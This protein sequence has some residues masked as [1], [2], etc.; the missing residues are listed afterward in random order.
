M[1]NEPSDEKLEKRARNVLLYQISRSMKTKR[2]LAQI[3]VK[4]EIPDHVALPL[5]DRFE[6][7]EL[8][9]DAAFARAFVVSK[10]A[11]GGKSA[12]ALRRELKIKGV[13]DDL[14]AEALIEL[15]QEKEQLIANRLAIARYQRLMKLEPDVRQRRLFGF[16]QRRGFNSAIISRAIR[17]A[18]AAG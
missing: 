14:I 13:A 16:L 10:L 5:L 1:P 7:A 15:D 8:I 4:R 17:E 6:E 3:L 18:Q 11:Q 9:N 12:M 2:Q